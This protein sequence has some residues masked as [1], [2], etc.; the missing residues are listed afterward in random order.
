MSTD[1]VEVRRLQAQV[2]GLQRI[3]DERDRQDD[4]FGPQR[5]DPAYWYAI[6]GKQF[7]QLGEVVVQSKWAGTVTTG[8]MRQKM[9]HEAQQVAAVALALM[10]AISLDELPDEITTARPRDP[11]QRAKAMGVGDE[12]LRYDTHTTVPVQARQLGDRRIED[13]DLPTNDEEV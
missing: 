6:L 11:R 8:L 1:K 4:E 5:H 9:Y 2:D 13:A 3:S 10:E 7:G 12:Q